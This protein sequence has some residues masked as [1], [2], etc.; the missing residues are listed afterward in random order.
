MKIYNISTALA[1]AAI[2]AVMIVA[3]TTTKTTLTTTTLTTTPNTAMAQ[4]TCTTDAE[5]GGGK[6][7]SIAPGQTVGQCVN[8][9]PERNVCP[10]GFADCNGVRGDQ[11]EVNLRQGDVDKQS[12]R[13]TNCGTCGET[14]PTGPE[15]T[16]EGQATCESGR[17]ACPTGTSP[18]T[19]GGET[20]CLAPC[21]PAEAREGFACVQTCTGPGATAC[22]AAN[23]GM[24]NV[25]TNTLTDEANCGGCANSGGDVCTSKETC[26]A[27]QCVPIPVQCGSGCTDVASN[28]CKPGN[29]ATACGSNGA[30]C[31]VCEGATPACIN[32]QCAAEPPAQCAANECRNAAGTC[33]AGNTNAA[34]GTAGVTCDTCTGTETCTNGQCTTPAPTA[35]TGNGQCP[36]GQV[37]NKPPGSNTGTC[38]PRP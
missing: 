1:I 27:G 37:C 4:S 21:G 2:A 29:T 8:V 22:P 10:S 28:T 6:S 26:T 25:C 18:V 9:K 30:L 34:C 32:G 15:G 38:G 20:R 23:P 16:T 31:T 11:C 12:G 7:C 17:C 14:C 24:G 5:C 3:A 13:V 19:S 33:V 36:S 35:C